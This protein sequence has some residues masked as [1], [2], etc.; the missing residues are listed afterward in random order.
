[1]NTRTVEYRVSRLERAIFGKNSNRRKP[2]L[3]SHQGASDCQ[4]MSF[5]QSLERVFS[6]DFRDEEVRY[7]QTPIACIKHV[8]NRL[9][10]K[11]E[12]RAKLRSLYQPDT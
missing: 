6:I 12:I 5:Y 9:N 2:Y 4:F 7:M 8:K 3:T 11:K 1:M 10:R